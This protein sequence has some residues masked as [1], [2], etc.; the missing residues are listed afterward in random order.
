MVSWSSPKKDDSHLL[1]LTPSR[2]EKLLELEDS[3]T[4]RICITSPS[5]FPAN[6]SQPRA[7]ARLFISKVIVTSLEQLF[8]GLKE[9]IVRKSSHVSELDALVNNFFSYNFAPRGYFFSCVV[10]SKAQSLP[11]VF[12]KGIQGSVR[13][14]FPALYLERLE[15]QQ[16]QGKREINM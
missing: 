5:P 1:S 13:K 3:N 15:R 16:T 4:K 12:M 11:K 8:I 6:T 14:G 9:L 10:N 2:D 7:L